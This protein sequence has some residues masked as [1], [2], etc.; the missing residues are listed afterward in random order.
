M[1]LVGA[2]FKIIMIDMLK[3]FNVRWIILAENWKLQKSQMD[4]I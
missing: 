2:K 4:I 1:V 3:K